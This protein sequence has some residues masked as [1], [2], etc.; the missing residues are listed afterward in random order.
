MNAVALQRSLGITAV[1]LDVRDE[2][3]LKSLLR[4]ANEGTQDHWQ[5]RD[6]LRTDVALCTPELVSSITAHTLNDGSPQPR[7]IPIVRDGEKEPS[8]TSALR[9]PFRIAELR[10]LLDEVSMLLRMKRSSIV[11][12][13]SPASV[14][15]SSN[16]HPLHPFKP[17]RFGLALNKLMERAS[18]EVHRLEVG[19]VVLHVIPAARALL[20]SEPLDEGA[21]SVLL[22]PRVD[23]RISRI[24]ERDAQRLISDGAKP[25]TIDWL[26]WR[27]G[28]DGP[29]NQLLPGLSEQSQF[30]L[31]RWP[32]FGRLKHKQSHFLMA[33]L[34]TRAAHSV[35]ELAL[36]SSQSIAEAYAFINACALCDLIEVR[37]PVVK[38]SVRGT[39]SSPERTTRYGDVFR[40]IRTV[41]GFRG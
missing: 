6:D 4:I 32:D 29:L 7:C 33:G 38:E 27:A 5:F 17:F 10:Q 13:S 40:S 20:L 16:V 1:G 19:R 9:A 3:L 22:E 31:K 37:Q 11:P 28:L 21:I 39:T 34:L 23:V 36:A 12:N 26:L 30:A 2:L 24:E 8:G 14:A 15:G 41:L 35:D 25:Q 18:R